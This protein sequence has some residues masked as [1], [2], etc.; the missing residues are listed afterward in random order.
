MSCK[1]AAEHKVDLDHILLES[2]EMED[3]EKH[4]DCPLRDATKRKKIC[5]VHALV[6]PKIE[7]FSKWQANC[8]NDDGS[9]NMMNLFPEHHQLLESFKHWAHNLE[10]MGAPIKG[11]W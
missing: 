1:T 7:E 9:D 2:F 11:A 10:E 8:K 4:D 3:D 6:M 5:K